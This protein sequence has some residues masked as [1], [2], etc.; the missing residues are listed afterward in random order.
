[1]NN[2]EPVQLSSICGI[3]GE[4]TGKTPAITTVYKW[5]RT[6]HRGVKLRV[7]GPVH[8]R[9]T[10]REWIDEFMSQCGGKVEDPHSVQVQ[11]A[12]SAKAKES[13]RT[14]FGFKYKRNPK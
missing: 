11:S 6:G 2:S 14:Q 7:S 1:M 12:E 4:L 8:F 5:I 9:F 10:T 3:I 13:L